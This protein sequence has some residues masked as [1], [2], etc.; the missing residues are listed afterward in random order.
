LDKTPF[1]AEAGGQV[2]DTGTIQLN[3]ETIHVENTMLGDSNSILHICEGILSEELLTKNIRCSVD[4]IRRQKIRANHSA[5]HL[6]HSALKNILGDHVHQAGS[7]VSPDYLRFDF[8]HPKK[9]NQDQL[10][11]IEKIVNGKVINNF[12]LSTEIKPYDVARREGAEALFGEKYGDD[13]RVISIGNFSIELCGGTHVNHTGEIGLFKII[14]ESSL[15]SGVRRIVAITG[16]KSLDFAQTQYRLLKEMMLKFNCSSTELMSR[17]D[18]IIND[19]KNLEKKLKQKPKQTAQDIGSLIS[20]GEPIGDSILVF[21]K[22]ENSNLDELKSIGDTLLQ[23]IKSGIGILGTIHDKKP[24]VVVV[25][26]ADLVQKGF[27]AGNITKH[28]GKMMNGGGGG[29]P[30]LATAGGKSPTHLDEAIME[31]KHLLKNKLKKYYEN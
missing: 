22:I 2:G 12:P 21:H 9:L 15:S 29:K 20:Q 18:Q 3:G 11:K 26:S 5:T 7:L 10:L 30:H 4:P 24:Q 19:K 14:E 1:Y 16:Q 31:G 23:N 6:L 17:V 13:V 25:I 8:T 28:M 27:H